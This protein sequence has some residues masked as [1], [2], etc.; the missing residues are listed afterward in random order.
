M[1]RWLIIL[2]LFVSVGIPQDSSNVE[3]PIPGIE[4][5][6][7]QKVIVAPQFFNQLEH[8]Y[9]GYVQKAV[10]ESGNQLV[11]L[12][13]LSDLYEDDSV[14]CVKPECL[15]GLN[16]GDSTS[17]YILVWEMDIDNKNMFLT[18]YSIDEAKVINRSGDTIPDATGRVEEKIQGLVEKCL[19]KKP[20]NWS[21]YLTPKHTIYTLGTAAIIWG[22]QFFSSRDNKDEAGIGLPPDWPN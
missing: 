6:K 4:K 19:N 14:L 3:S 5:S 22:I 17:V 13:S 1:I 9:N 2:I 12:Q 21:K 20:I 16:S 10:T 18:L 8:L 11:L 7:P 15:E